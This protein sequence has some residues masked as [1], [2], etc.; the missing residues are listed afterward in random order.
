MLWIAVLIL[1]ALSLLF[2]K[3]RSFTLAAIGVAIVA[4]V[5]IVV[6]AKRNEA[7]P[8][9]AAR[10]SAAQKPID[11]ERFLVEKLDKA[12]PQAKNR[13]P[14]EEIR[15]AQARAEAGA[16]RGSISK[17]VARLYNDSAIYTLTDYEYRLVVQDCIDAAC[18][19]VFDQR[20]LS[21]VSVPPR[22]ARD[23]QIAIREEGARDMPPVR[24]LG[25][26]NILLTPVATRAEPA[27]KAA[28]D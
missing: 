18:T 9:A 2:P 13:I 24:I 15:F 22:Q 5:A 3:T 8:R 28:L 21:A 26:A 23:V 10:P 17:I 20:G 14:V 27:G 4:F 16:Q 25:T 1:I 19:A 12:D 11:F 6:L 7:P